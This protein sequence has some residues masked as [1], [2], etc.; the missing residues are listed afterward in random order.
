[1]L[2]LVQ[3]REVALLSDVSG[4]RR[5][6]RGGAWGERCCARSSWRKVSEYSRWLSAIL[7]S[8]CLICIDISLPS[9][10]DVNCKFVITF[11]S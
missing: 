7:A 5:V 6:L 11:T 3:L 1:M 10:C 9:G 2:Q 8:Q 4:D